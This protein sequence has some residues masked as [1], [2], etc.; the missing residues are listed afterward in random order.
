MRDG[1]GDVGVLRQGIVLS[2]L[3]RKSWGSNQK[4]SAKLEVLIALQNERRP[5]ATLV[6]PRNAAP[7]ANAS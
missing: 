7:A 1:V 4:Y 5:D 3:T 2:A 6:N